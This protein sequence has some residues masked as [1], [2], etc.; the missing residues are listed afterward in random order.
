MAGLSKTAVDFSV[1]ESDLTCVRHDTGS[2]VI[3]AGV[4]LDLEAK[5]HKNTDGAA[6]GFVTFTLG[7]TEADTVPFSMDASDDTLRVKTNFILPYDDYLSLAEDDTVSAVFKAVVTTG[8]INY[9]MSGA[10]NAAIKTVTVNGTD[11]EPNDPVANARIDSIT[12]TCDLGNNTVK[13][14]EGVTFKANISGPGGRYTRVYYYIND[15][16]VGS[17]QC[18]LSKSDNSALNS[19]IWWVPWSASGSLDLKIVLENGVQMSMTVPVAT[20][21]YQLRNQGISWDLGR[22]TA[23]SLVTIR[24]K[25]FKDSGAAFDPCDAMRAVFVVNGTPRPSPSISTSRQPKRR[26]W[27]KPHTATGYRTTAPGR[28][29]SRSWRTPADCSR[30]RARATTSHP[31]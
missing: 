28:W 6:S 5:V 23:G 26:I 22:T 30:K 14:G 9:E 16:M 1:S 29:T 15:K 20:Y 25:V 17:K 13:P 27:P 31:H 7:G 4:R 10:N 2:A 19:F 11:M 3:R 24:C 18:Y 12:T 21:D 8:D